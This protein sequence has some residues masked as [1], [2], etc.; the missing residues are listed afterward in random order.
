MYCGS[1]TN[2]PVEK[3]DTLMV[4]ELAQTSI[5]TYISLNSI[6]VSCMLQVVTSVTKSLLSK[7]SQKQLPSWKETERTSH[8]RMLLFNRGVYEDFYKHLYLMHVKGKCKLVL[9]LN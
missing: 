2:T 6:T 1:K 8:K 9:V 7:T 3:N 5:N 4:Q